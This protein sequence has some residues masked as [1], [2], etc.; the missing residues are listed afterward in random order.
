MITNNK[1][2]IEYEFDK[3]DKEVVGLLSSSELTVSQLLT[4]LKFHKFGDISSMELTWKL[5]DLYTL[6]LIKRKLKNGHSKIYIY[7]IENGGI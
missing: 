5:H 7:Y 1:I 3:I 4:I 2:T 6:G